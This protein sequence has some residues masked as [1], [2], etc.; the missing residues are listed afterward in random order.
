M[1]SDRLCKFSDLYALR[2]DRKMQ[3]AVKIAPAVPQIVAV[4]KLAEIK[5]NFRLTAWNWPT[6]ARFTMAQKLSMVLVR[7]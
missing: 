6:K 1:S 7:L 5:R 2:L 3:H 4:G